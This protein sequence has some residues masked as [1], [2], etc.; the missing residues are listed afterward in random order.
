MQTGSCLCISPKSRFYSTSGP[1]IKA[2]ILSTALLTFRTPSPWP[3]PVS[4]HSA[5]LCSGHWP[6]LCPPALVS[7]LMLFQNFPAPLRLPGQDAAH[8]LSGLPPTPGFKGIFLTSA[9][10]ALGW[11]HFSVFTVWH[12]ICREK[13]VFVKCIRPKCKVLCLPP[14]LLSSPF[15]IYQTVGAQ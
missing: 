6:W 3:S 7:S 14:N 13:K 5:P 2:R 11:Y 8:L 10:K 15:C 1:P 12:T 9:S 4:W